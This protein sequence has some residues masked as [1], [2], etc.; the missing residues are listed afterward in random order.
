MKVVWSPLALA[1]VIEIATYI[2]QDKPAA[3]RGWTI[4]VFKK[5]EYL[6]SFPESGRQAPETRRQDIREIIFTSYRII[7]RLRSSHVDVLAVRHAKQ[8]FDLKGHE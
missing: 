6:A 1:R 4:K 5:V 8:R 3:A 7:Y 2:A